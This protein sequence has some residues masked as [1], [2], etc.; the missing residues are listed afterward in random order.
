[1]ELNTP[2]FDN[3]VA[4]MS[5][6]LSILE[7]IRQRCIPVVIGADAH[8]PPRVAVNSEDARDALNSVGYT[9]VSLFLNGVSLDI[10]IDL[11]RDS[12]RS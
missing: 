11:A 9:E 3:V 8:D 2:G 4:E 10:S 5:P 6:G 12:L 7:E 1:M